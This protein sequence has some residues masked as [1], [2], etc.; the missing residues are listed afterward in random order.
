MEAVQSG[1]KRPRIS[2]HEIG[3]LEIGEPKWMT[4]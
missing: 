3:G 1:G 4:T 2:S